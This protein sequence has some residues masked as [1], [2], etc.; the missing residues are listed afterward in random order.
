MKSEGLLRHEPFTPMT[1]PFGAGLVP[2][3]HHNDGARNMMGPRTS[4]RH[5]P[6]P[7]AQDLWITTGGEEEVIKAVKPLIDAGICPDAGDK[8]GNLAFEKDLLVAYLPGRVLTLRM[9]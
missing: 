2:V 9:P 1:N 4:G 3:Y 8:E 5:C 6:F 7:I